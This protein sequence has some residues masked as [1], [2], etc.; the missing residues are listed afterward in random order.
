MP[1]PQ[2][3]PKKSPPP[4][5]RLGCKSPRVGQIFGANPRGCA[6]GWLWMKLIPHKRISYEMRSQ[7][8]QSV[9]SRG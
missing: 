9:I 2:E 7:W 5:Q 3:L 8:N 1:A 6:G 4:G